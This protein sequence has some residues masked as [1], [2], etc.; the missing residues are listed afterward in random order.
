MSE[1]ETAMPREY[2]VLIIGGGPAGLSAGIY[3][4][5]SRLSGLL[6]EKAMLG[7]LI[8]N[9]EKVENY[10]GFPDGV[11]GIEIGELMQRQAGKFGLETVIGEVAGLEL[12]GEMKTVKTST[13]DYTAGAV[14]V[15]SGSEH[16]KLDV[17]GEDQFT[18]KGVSFCA[19]CDGY[20]FQ[21]KTVAIVGGGNAALSEALLLTK[22]A[23]KVFV[24]HR[25][26]ELRATRIV[27]EK[28]RAE[29]KIEFR[30]NSAVSAI[31]GKDFVEKLKLRNPESGETSTLKVDGVFIAAGFK[32]STDF[33]KTVLPLDNA[34]YVVTNEKMETAVAG[35]FAAGDVRANSIRQVITAA[36]DGA[37]AAVY[38]E[39]YLGGRR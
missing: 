20:F 2:E 9:A 29:P 13:G 37:T 23:K 10:P 4:A 17:P 33:L 18:G 30:L 26:N 12:N 28:A 36:G 7:G 8:A 21:D 3:T 38:A 32:P 1:G 35:I 25:R 16:T 19:T 6:I 24:I 22:F 27:Q 15:A 11:S 39:R 5:R 34:G 31:E 14:I